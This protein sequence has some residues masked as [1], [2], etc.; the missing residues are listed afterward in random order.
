MRGFTQDKTHLNVINATRISHKI[1]T[2]LD[3][4]KYTEGIN[5]LNV[6]F[7]TR[8]SHKK[9]TGNSFE[10]RHWEEAIYICEICEKAFSQNRYLIEHAKIHSN[11]NPYKWNHCEKAFS[12]NID[13]TTHAK[14]H[15][16]NRPL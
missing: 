8:L 7:V 11:V 10:N 15:T 16:G 5:Y 12:W 9:W 13:L 4:Q 2:L 3:I 1:V 14:I 6:I